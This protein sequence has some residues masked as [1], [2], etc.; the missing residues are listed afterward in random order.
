MREIAKTFGTSF[1]T[2]M[3]DYICRQFPEHTDTVQALQVKHATFREVCA[4]YEE[5]C[6]WLAAQEPSQVSDPEEWA[7]AREL[8]LDLEDE[9]LKFLEDS[10]ESTC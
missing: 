10:H 9:I 2:V 4:D 5:I 6:A 1:I 3:G 7:H 8:K